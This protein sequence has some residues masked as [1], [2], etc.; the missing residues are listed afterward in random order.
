MSVPVS[1]PRTASGSRTALSAALR[2]LEAAGGVAGLLLLFVAWYGEIRLRTVWGVVTVP[3]FDRTLPV[4]AALMIVAALALRWRR[5]ETL[6]PGMDDS[7]L[8]RSGLAWLVGLLFLLH[9]GLLVRS[10]YLSYYDHMMKVVEPVV[11]PLWQSL[12][13]YCA[14]GL[15]SVAAWLTTRRQG[16]YAGATV[17]VVVMAFS[18]TLLTVSGKVA[19][20]YAGALAAWG[21]LAVVAGLLNRVRTWLIWL[22]AVGLVVAGTLLLCATGH[23]WAGGRIAGLVRESLLLVPAMFLLVASGIWRVVVAGGRRSPAFGGAMLTMALAVVVLGM[24]PP[25]AGNGVIL[26]LPAAVVLAGYGAAQWLE[27]GRKLAGVYGRNIALLLVTAL[28]LASAQAG[29]SRPVSKSAEGRNES[30][31]VENGNGA[32][33]EEK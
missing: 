21:V 3:G 17:A 25:H 7:Q 11:P 26:A 27:W 18:P 4:C 20:V 16:G 9:A 23:S 1:N 19:A 24:R 32:G 29:L 8:T 22:V 13:V 5:D 14:A 15:C 2:L 31:E 10:W 12:A 30:V 33:G 28:V 6:E